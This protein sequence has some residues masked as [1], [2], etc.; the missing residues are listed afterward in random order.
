MSN[1]NTKY[2]SGKPL[3]CR[4]RNTPPSTY[5]RKLFAAPN[6]DIIDDTPDKVCSFTIRVNGK[7][8]SEPPDKKKK[9]QVDAPNISMR[10]YKDDCRNEG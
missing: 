2:G 1:L 4:G 3:D 8:V 5:G 10:Q 9:K 6:I 7:I